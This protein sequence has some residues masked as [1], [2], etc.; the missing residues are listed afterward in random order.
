[1]QRR[2]WLRRASA[3]PARRGGPGQ[4][5]ALIAIVVLGF[6]LSGAGGTGAYYYPLLR[7]A[8]QDTG[9]KATITPHPHASTS[10]HPAAPAAP[11]PTSGGGF[12]QPFTVLLLGSDND[13]KSGNDQTPLSQSVILVRVNPQAD[14][15]VML[16]LPR[17]LII[18]CYDS[19]GDDVG[20]Q[21]L[22]AC[23]EEGTFPNDAAAAM[24]QT[25]QNNFDIQVDDWAWIGLQGLVNLINYVGG[26]D[27]VVSSP[28]MDDLY[29]ADVGTPNAYGYQRLAILPGPQHMTGEQALDYVRTRHAS[30]YGDFSRSARQQQILVALRQK[31]Q[32]LTPADLPAIESAMQGQ[33]YTSMTVTQMAQLLP[34]APAIKDSAVTQLTLAAPQY[35]S[36]E[37]V[38]DPDGEPDD[39]V[40]GNFGAI[41]QLIWQYFPQ[42]QATG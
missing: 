5:I 38:T 39:V 2:R 21:K 11:I 34:L 29:P 19:S 9:R 26:V 30:T 7:A 25:I 31:L 6:A 22:D 32:Y 4:T 37:T 1:M 42:V 10:A 14:S 33:F 24:T 18:D 27:V 13:G 8:A 3:P 36:E 23:F 28:V 41:D 20:S 12:G 16:S 15:V 35:T 17:D 40:E